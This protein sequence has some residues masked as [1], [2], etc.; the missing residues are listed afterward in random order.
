[1]KRRSCIAK[2]SGVVSAGKEA[3]VYW[4]RS[5]DGKELA[6]KIFLTSSAEFR[7]SIWKYI[8]GDSRFEDVRNVSMHKLM[9]IWARKEYSNL[10]RMYDAGVGVPKPMCVHRNVLVME[11][12]GEN[13][14]RAPLLREVYRFQPPDEE[15]SKYYF[16]TLVKSVYRMYWYAELVHG[17]LSEYNVMIF[18]ETPYIIDVSQAVGIEHPNANQLLHR[19]ISNVVRFFSEEVGLEV[20]STNELFRVI[21][22]REIEKLEQL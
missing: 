2:L 7:K 17:D 10:K 6:I 22:N 19:D 20:P 18:K 5:S 4:G 13:G 1:M 14:V 21:V 8:Q 11:F 9:S 3:R 12:L 15:K 16:S